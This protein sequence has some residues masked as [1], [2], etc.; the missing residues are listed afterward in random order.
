MI[1][2][3]QLSLLLYT[4]RSLCSFI[5]HRESV[6]G[7]IK[8]TWQFSE[9]AEYNAIK[10]LPFKANNYIFMLF[11]ALCVPGPCFSPVLSH[12]WGRTQDV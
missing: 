6:E 7:I 1:E 11:T 4:A 5:A 3:L 2:P 12:S 8:K 9:K 10:V